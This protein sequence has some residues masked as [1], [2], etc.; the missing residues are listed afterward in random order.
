MTLERLS[1][2]NFYLFNR[3]I[4]LY[5]SAFPKEERRDDLEQERVLKKEDYHFNLIMDDGVFIGVMLYWETED[6]VFLEHFTT[7]PELRGKG[8]GKTALELLKKKNKIILLEIEPLVNELTKRRYDFYKRNGFLMNPYYHIQAKYHLGDED[9]ELKVLSYPK[10]L[11][12]EQYQS[13]YEYMTREI[14][15][16]ANKATDVI[17]RG[18]NDNDDL[19]QVAKLIYLTD[20]YVY[21]N[22]F[23]D[24]QSGIKVIREMIDL[25]TLYNRENI[26]V[27]VQEN[28][29]I[30]GIIVSK[31]SPFIED[32]GVLCKA[33][34]L[35]GITLDKRTKEVFEAYYSKMGGE[36][37]GFYIANVAVDEQCRKRGI[38]ASLV[39]HVIADK[40]FC[41]L[42]CVV[43]NTGS[44]RLYQRLGFKIAYEY[45][46]VHDVP[47]YK[48]IY[49]K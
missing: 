39:N 49:K 5:K 30:A 18:L 4:E 43:A 44:W 38:A 16:Q 40:T 8:F 28:G 35:A 48:M 1:N 3:A 12:A 24:I 25:P 14:G 23:D 29:F 26:T 17:I 36:E 27:A 13:F 2:H 11:T 10:I 45:P 47:C 6:F 15:I 22:W 20:P 34:D 7:L 21:P 46:G 32:Y 42:E 19:D 33:F 37:D 31:Q 9:L 41:T